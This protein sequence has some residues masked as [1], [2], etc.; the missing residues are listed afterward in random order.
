MIDFF[1]NLGV[2]KQFT[3]DIW[4]FVL[5]VAISLVFIA[6]IKK[7]NLGAL[8]ISIYV[9]FGIVSKSFFDFLEEPNLKLVYF[10]A[11]TTLLFQMFRSFFRMGIGGSKVAMWTK[12]ILV[13]FSAV[14]LLGSIVITWFPS[15]KVAEIFSPL[16]QQLFGTSQAQ[17]F[18][19]VA[20]VVL[21]FVFMRRRM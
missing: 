10:L 17:L 9:S 18:W 20:P 8:L 2:P 14:G 7:R 4:L 11:I 16:S 19:M 12:T 6:L 1:S 3:G 5:F 21:I 13:A 15:D